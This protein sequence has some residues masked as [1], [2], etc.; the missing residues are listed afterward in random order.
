[1]DQSSGAQQQPEMPNVIQSHD[2]TFDSAYLKCAR[3]EI[4]PFARKRRL[5]TKCRG[6]STTVMF[7][8][9]WVQQLD[10]VLLAEPL[11]LRGCHT[12][13]P[14]LNQERSGAADNVPV[15][16]RSRDAKEAFSKDSG[17]SGIESDRTHEWS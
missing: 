5:E 16:T 3:S 10:D 13:V 9:F 11:S 17:R 1:M 2:H 6:C 12:W 15:R 14:A 4:R 8:C 7:Q